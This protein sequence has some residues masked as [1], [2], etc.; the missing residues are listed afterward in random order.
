MHIEAI[1]Q[2]I[3]FRPSRVVKF[4]QHRGQWMVAVM[5]HDG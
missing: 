4:R 1:V 2:V 5:A 3:E